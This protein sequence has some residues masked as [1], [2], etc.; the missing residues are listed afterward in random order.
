MY[1]LTYTRDGQTCRHALA[2]GDTIVG[3]ATVCDLAIED[4][5]I[6]R[7]HVRFRIHGDRCVITDLGGRNGVFLNGEQV[8]EA[9]ITGGDSIVLGRFPLR[10]EHVA[11]APV[12]FS[13]D[14]PVLES[15]HTL[16]RRVDAETRPD[17]QPAAHPERLLLLLSEISRQLVRWRPLPE[18][19]DRIA[20]VVFDT[21]AVERAFLLLIDE[22]TRELVP[23]VVRARDGS[24]IAEPRLSRTILQRSIDERIAV[25]S[26][27]VRLESG[28]AAAPSVVEGRVR[29]FMCAPLWNQNTVIGALYVDNPHTT[30]LTAADLE[31]LQALSSYAAVA[32]EQARLSG[33]I[34]EERRQRELLQRYHSAAVVDR[35]LALRPGAD[36]G[37][38][39]EERDVSVLFADIVGF[40][41]RAERL[42]P[43]AVAELLNR[44][45]AAMCDAVF[46]EEGTLDKFIGDEVL[47][48]FS[49]PLTQR[50]HAARALRVAVAM[51]DSVAALDIQPPVELRI[52]INSGVATVG[53]IGTPKRREYTVL[54]D[55]VN[56]CARLVDD[57]CARG[58]IVLT[59]ATRDRLPSSIDL[60]PMGPV[61]IRG[62]EA[63]VDLF[64]YAPPS[65]QTGSAATAR[66]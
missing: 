28:L 1:I 64:E 13:D 56:T 8:T 24:P 40:T 63:P 16:F 4:P 3:R 10:I 35:I 41:T 66:A 17:V 52:A 39:A 11:A 7:R 43:S 27:D 9:Q 34:L 61:T 42:T 30:A 59:A 62:R 22:S 14:H 60:R 21:I 47:A 58:Q 29:S 6:S 38:L 45:F 15:A 5:S 18:I 25:L 12:L 44:C 33:R 65:T 53:D 37:L 46:A 51:R 50:D 32:I 19:L 26:S 57:A 55:V 23:H 36:A 2:P 54:G 48:V 31:V 49:A 20:S